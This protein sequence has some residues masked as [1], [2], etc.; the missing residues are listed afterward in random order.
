MH[1]IRYYL[2]VLLALKNGPV[3]VSVTANALAVRNLLSGS[4]V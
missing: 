2:P 1:P 4:S 3:T